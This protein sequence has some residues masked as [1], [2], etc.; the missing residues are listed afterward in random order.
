MSERF[1]DAGPGTDENA[2]SILSR[3]ESGW[4][5]DAKISNLKD[6]ILVGTV[7]ETSDELR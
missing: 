4:Q 3:G 5:A 7:N 6:E 2:I 1:I